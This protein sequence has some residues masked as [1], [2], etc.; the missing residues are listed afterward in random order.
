MQG[1]LARRQTLSSSRGL[2]GLTHFCL[3]Y[4][5]A[6]IQM[7]AARA[8]SAD[9]KWGNPLIRA[10]HWLFLQQALGRHACA[11]TW[12]CIMNDKLPARLRYCPSTKGQ[13]AP[14]AVLKE[15]ACNLWTEDHLMSNCGHVPV[16]TLRQHCLQCAERP[17][18][19]TQ[20][21]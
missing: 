21:T 14:K 4:V 10:R 15:M 12:M 3:A 5:D 7:H 19:V 13:R 11:N 18:V 17:A 1:S 6:W 2:L 20:Y 16:K 9:R 8:C